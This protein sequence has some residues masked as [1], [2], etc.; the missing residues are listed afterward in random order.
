MNDSTAA[1]YLAQ[2][3]A[4]P[5]E[6]VDLDA[7]IQPA[8]VGITGLPDALVLIKGQAVPPDN[9]NRT[10]TWC[11]VG[12]TLIE[13]TANADDRHDGTGANGLG[14]SQISRQEEIEVTASFYGP[15]SRACAAR[16]RDGLSV[17]QNRD[18]LAFA[19]LIYVRAE[20][21][22]GLAEMENQQFVRRCDIVLHF[23]RMVGRTYPI[24][25]I[26]SV[27]G[28]ASSVDG[29]APVTSSF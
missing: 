3:D 5:S 15:A 19:G 17:A 25:N 2:T 8:V 24:R 27:V 9:P 14:T 16:L 20:R 21:L 6:D 29:P 10:L 28:T 7:L 4:P 11:A 18:A 26:L 12:T 13:A 23:R 22:M 1:G